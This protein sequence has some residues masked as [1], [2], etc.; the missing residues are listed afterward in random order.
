MQ[1]LANHERYWKREK[2]LRRGLNSGSIACQAIVLATA[3][4]SLLEVLA[5]FTTSWRPFPSLSLLFFLS[6]CFYLNLIHYLYC[7]LLCILHLV[8]FQYSLFLTEELIDSSLCMS[9]SIQLI[10]LPFSLKHQTQIHLSLPLQFC[11]SYKNF[12]WKR[13]NSFPDFPE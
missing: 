7:V 11:N 13:K 12:I 8:L 3:L 5:F 10:L 6:L 2:W 1:Y 9:T 4:R